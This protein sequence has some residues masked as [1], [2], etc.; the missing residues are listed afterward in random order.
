MA[1]EKYPKS[2]ALL[3]IFLG[4]YSLLVYTFAVGLLVA[5]STV[6]STDTSSK[7]A[8]GAGVF[9]GILIVL[10]LVGMVYPVVRL[11]RRAFPREE[12]P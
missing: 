4:F 9:L 3:F 2:K 6:N 7:S 8:L 5:L 10:S 11:Y 12:T 1:R